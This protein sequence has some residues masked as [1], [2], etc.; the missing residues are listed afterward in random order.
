MRLV[1]AIFGVLLLVPSLAFAQQWAQFNPPPMKDEA[2][3]AAAN[4]RLAGL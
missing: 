1:G 3:V 4:G 2:P